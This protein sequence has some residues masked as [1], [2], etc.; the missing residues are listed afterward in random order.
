MSSWE[1]L[2]PNRYYVAY[3]KTAAQPTPVTAR[4]DMSVYGS[5]A[6]LPAAADLLALTPEQW[7]ALPTHGIG[8]Q[9]GAIIDYTPPAPPVPLQT[10]A[11]N[12]QAWITQQANLAAAMGETFTADMK[13]YVL[14]INAIASGTDTTS[15]ALPAQPTDVMT[16]STAAATT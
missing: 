2:Y 8:V 11:K 6:G 10:Q 7:A 4:Y 12:A 16:A 13:A 3:D 1:N 9:N 15:T 5:L 14:A